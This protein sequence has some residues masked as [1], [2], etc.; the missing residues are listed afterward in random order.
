[1]KSLKENVPK[2]QPKEKKGAPKSESRPASKNS[3]A[4]DKVPKIKQEIK[5]SP[6]KTVTKGL[7]VKGKK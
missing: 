4:A 5:K 2:V 1:L 7:K 6:K 3:K